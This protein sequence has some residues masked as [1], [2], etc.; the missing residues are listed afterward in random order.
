MRTTGTVM[1]KFRAK[2]NIDD[3][4][5]IAYVITLM[6]GLVMVYSTSS[7]I[8]E[9]RFGS[10]WFF[11]KNQVV[12]GLLSLGAVFIISKFDLKKLA[13]YS[14]PA[15]L[16]TLV[17]LSLVFIMPARNGSHRWLMLGTFTVQPSELFKFLLIV[18]LAFSLSNQRRNIGELKQLIFP[19]VPIIGVGLGLILIE[20]DLGSCIVTSAT[21]IGM[22][23]LAGARVKHL[24]IGLLASATVAT[25][26]VF[27]VG[28]KA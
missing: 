20:P 3:R 7:I 10:Q 28:Y 13:V 26:F 8:A 17:L 27:V 5:L 24:A 15:L 22:F 19:Y 14:A 25:F 21:V 1:K 6:T 2:S 4:L 11:F 23:F 16:V 18:F 12:W 9:A